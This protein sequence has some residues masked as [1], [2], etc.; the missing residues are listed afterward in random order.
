LTIFSDNPV[1]LRKL[2]ENQNAVTIG[3]WEADISDGGCHLHFDPFEKEANNKT[4][5]NN[6]KFHI[7]FKNLEVQTK[8][9]VKE[10]VVGNSGNCRK[11]LEVS[12]EECSGRND[13]DIFTVKNRAQNNT[14]GH[15][16]GTKFHAR[17]EH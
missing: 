9:K 4:W 11:E 6:P 12:N 1:E 13:R 7:Q 10:L 16:S 17:H 2:D 8:L 14:V 5:T 15:G 3:K